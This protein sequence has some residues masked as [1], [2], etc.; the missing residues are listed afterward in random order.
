MEKG[1]DI[2]L[3][4][5]I[6][7]YIKGHLSETESAAFAA[8]IAADK[9]LAE[10]VERQQLH[11]EALDILLEDD[12]RHKMKNWASEADGGNTNSSGWKT[13]GFGMGVIVVL[14]SLYFLFKPKNDVIS[15]SNQ[16]TIQQDSLT[17]KQKEIE[18]SKIDTPPTKPNPTIQQLK[19][20]PTVSEPKK[21]IA[22]AQT[23]PNDLLTP[24]NDDLAMVLTEL[25]KNEVRGGK[26][27]D[28][29]LSESY[30]L[31]RQKE[32]TK[33]KNALKNVQNTEGAF[34]RAI[35][36]FLNKEYTKALPIFENLANNTGF[37]HNE[38]AEYYG[39]L[40]FWA[41]GQKEEA[42]QRLTKMAKDSEHQY[43]NKAKTTLK[44]LGH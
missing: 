31:I 9:D 7:A 28:S 15:T 5:K 44:Q 4:I 26:E 18:K 35:T 14:A 3:M 32:Y 30:R 41:N 11:L 33:A 37:N 17:I 20:T 8:D 29:L 12:L 19:K 6:D 34:I 23:L 24:A 27:T 2:E 25:E 36:Y 21:P 40:C 22:S 10:R 16:K 1:D 38:T 39:T 42:V 43:A 13:W